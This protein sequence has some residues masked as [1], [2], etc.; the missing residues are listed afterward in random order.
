LPRPHSLQLRESFLLDSTLRWEDIA[1]DEGVIRVRRQL[2]RDRHPA[3]L[4]TARARRDVVL[5]PQLAKMLRE[6]RMASPFKQPHDY[7]FAAPGGEGRDHRSTSKAVERAIARA[8]LSGVSFHS[9]RHGF[10]SMLIVGLKSDVE[11]VSRQLGHADSSITLRIYSHEFDKTRN[12]DDLRD[13]L[14]AAVG[15]LMHVGASV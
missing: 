7:V 6:H 10:A 4:K 1:S 5:I 11:T 14:G 2:G 15:V 3:E 9:L 12:M 8:G 13:S